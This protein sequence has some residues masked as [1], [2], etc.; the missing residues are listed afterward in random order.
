MSD[1]ET[2]VKAF[3]GDLLRSLPLVSDGF[4]LDPEL[5]VMLF[6]RNARVEEVPITYHARSIAEGRKIRWYHGFRTLWALISCRMAT[7]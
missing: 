5:T 6:K 2:G 4:E 3:R 1:M 7:G